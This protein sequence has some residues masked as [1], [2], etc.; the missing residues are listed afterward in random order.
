MAS[1]SHLLN[2]V[3]FQAAVVIMIHRQQITLVEIVVVTSNNSLLV[4]MDSPL[5]ATI[6]CGRNYLPGHF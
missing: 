1:S 4:I 2:T 6:S 3:G 5:L